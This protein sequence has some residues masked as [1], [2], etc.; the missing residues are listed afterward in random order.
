VGVSYD[1]FEL[2]HGDLYGDSGG[3][4]AP[5]LDACAAVAPAAVRERVDGLRVGDGVRG[6]G[7]CVADLMPMVLAGES[8]FCAFR[9]T[10]ATGGGVWAR[11]ARVDALRGTGS[12]SG[13]AFRRP[14]GRTRDGMV[15]CANAWIVR[16]WNPEGPVFFFARVVHVGLF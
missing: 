1:E 9:V 7:A 13:G 10:I 4:D 3:R 5:V 12:S 16:A 14:L 11:Q 8:A 15:M 2:S 6:G